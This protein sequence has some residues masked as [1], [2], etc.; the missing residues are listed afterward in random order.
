M[1]VVLYR[2]RVNPQFEEQFIESWAEITKY[3]L[4]NFGSRG[5]RLHRGGDGIFYAYAQWKSDEDRRKAF[6]GKLNSDVGA[7]MREA[8]EE[9]FPE[10]ELEIVSDFLL[11]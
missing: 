8:I 2:W 10:V 6:Q 9:S 4:E 11:C 7:K 1:F 5:S 3:Y